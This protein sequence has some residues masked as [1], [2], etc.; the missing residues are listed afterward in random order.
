MVQV[1]SSPSATTANTIGATAQLP[2]KCDVAGD[3]EWVS[4]VRAICKNNCEGLTS[5]QQNILWQE[6]KDIFALNDSEVGLMQR[7]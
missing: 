7:T 2:P 5:Q 3:E 4:I 1:C 6:S